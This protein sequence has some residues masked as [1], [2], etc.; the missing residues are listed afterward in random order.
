M[1]VITTICVLLITRS[2]AHLIDS[3]DVVR[4]RWTSPVVIEKY[5]LIFFCT[6]KVACTEFMTLLRRMMNKTDLPIREDIH[7]EKVNGLRYLYHYNLKTASEMMIDPTWTKAIFLREPKERILSAYLS[8][9]KYSKHYEI[10]CCRRFRGSEKD[11]CIEKADT[12]ESFLKN[13]I[14]ECDDVHWRPQNEYLGSKYARMIN[15]VGQFSNLAKDTETLLRSLEGDAWERHGS[16]FEN[17]EKRATH[18]ARLLK[19]YYTTELE[20]IVKEKFAEDY[21][22]INQL[23]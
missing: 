12:F 5:K 9:V 13:A 15:F 18:A 20:D 23:K 6:S 21:E 4:Q 22:L 8:K 1:R 7:I 3:K 10:V 19:Q 17:A 16:S 11:K 2:L 14:D